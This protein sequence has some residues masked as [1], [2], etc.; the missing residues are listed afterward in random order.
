MG[1]ERGAVSTYYIIFCILEVVLLLIGVFRIGREERL[2]FHFGEE[3]IQAVEE[4][5]CTDSI[6]LDKGIYDITVRFEAS[7]GGSIS[8]SGNGKGPRSIYADIVW[9]SANDTS[10]TFQIWANDPL[11][12]FQ[13]KVSSN[14]GELSVKEVE[15]R[16]A[17]QSKSYQMV[18]WF[19]KLAL[20]NILVSCY[21][22]RN[23]LKKYSVEIMGIAGITFLASVA[24]MARYI[25][26]GHDLSFHLLRIEGLK[27]G[28]ISGAFPVR[29]QPNWCNGWGYAV[30]VMYGDTMLILP[31]V[32]R[33]LGFTVQ[34][35]YKTFVIMINLMTA[36]TAWYCF[37]KICRNRYV[38]LLGSLMYTAAPYRL[39]CIYIRAAFGEYVAMM[40]LPLIALGFWYAFCEKTDREDYGKK[41]LAPVIGFSGLIQ[42]HILTCQ[43]TAIFIVLLCL[44]MI[45]KVLRKKTFIY[46]AK[47]VCLTVA[48]NLWFLVPFFRYFRED[49]VCSAATEMAAD[50]Q[51]LGVSLAELFAQETSGYYAYNWSELVSLG[52]KFSIPLG[53]GLLL[54]A[55]FGI[56]VLWNDKIKDRKAVQVVL[57]FGL[58][59]VWMATNL[60]PYHT[61]QIYM[62][63]VAAFLAKPGLPYRY[64][65][66][67]CLFLALL[68]V[69]IFAK[70][71]NRL[72][73]NFMIA[74]F[75]VIAGAAVYQ[76][77][78]FSYQT[79]YSGEYR[80]NYDGASISTMELMGKEYLYQG[81]EI[82]IAEVDK[83]AGGM[84]VT[85][86]D[87]SKRYNS[88]E[89]TCRA[90]GPEAFLE[91]PMFYY[92]GYTAYDLNTTG[93][94]M[95][96]VRGSNNRIRVK[97][98]E[99]YEGT[100]RIR[101]KEPVSWRI[102]ELI[103]VLTML[104]IL[105]WR[106]G[107]KQFWGRD[108]WSKVGTW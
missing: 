92:P 87:S 47:I 56:L 89:V 69:L 27:E 81:T 5:L 79:L 18:C 11:E 2:Y 86:L 51:I 88:M 19:L 36:L 16:T 46:L 83:T 9:I 38:S 75:F 21:L 55:V 85:I 105:A 70:T 7:E 35:A 42:T 94:I 3:N 58:L 53:N 74:M 71:E 59:S 12:W 33:M 45:K 49:L 15:I 78:S 50:Y 64:L 28:L 41:Y 66:L 95:E 48:A 72:K 101:F 61:L 96:V 1:K 23:K 67:S 104:G 76:A 84:A 99:G 100:V 43:M 103:S 25:L 32:M 106:L 52:R 30:S 63:K 44:I 17:D 90:E 91:V 102:A 10:K 80:V 22:L 107:K 54:C 97:L 40:F 82:E 6:R 65:S 60:F 98:P 14:G 24:M 26:P 73:Q 37:Y 13:V 57:A 20:V 77:F 8:V 4:M 108:Q 34:T 31:A 68:G 29:I 62:P 93:E 39:C